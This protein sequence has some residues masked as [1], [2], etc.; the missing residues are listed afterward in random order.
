MTS[1]S[2]HE[3]QPNWRIPIE[4]L[5]EFETSFS[6]ERAFCSSHSSPPADICDYVQ[7]IQ[8]WPDEDMEKSTHLH[9]QFPEDLTEQCRY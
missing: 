4:N 3:K 5:Q 6:T 8:G 9:L 7:K 2:P 1:G